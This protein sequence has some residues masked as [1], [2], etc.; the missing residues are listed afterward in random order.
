MEIRII[1]VGQKGIALL[2]KNVP[3]QQKVGQHW[4]VE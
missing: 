3:E 1:Q 4:R 2:L